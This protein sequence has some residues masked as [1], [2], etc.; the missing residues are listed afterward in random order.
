MEVQVADSGPCRKTLTIAIPPDEI[1]VR[2]DEAFATAAQ[3]VEVKGFRKGKVPRKFLEKKYGDAIRAQ[4][5][6][7]LVNQSLG[8]ACRDHDLAMVGRPDVDELGDAPLSEAEPLEFKVHLDV[9]PQFELQEVKGIEVKTGETAVSDEELET[10]LQQ[11][12]DQKKTLKSVDEPVAEGDFVKVDLEFRDET[13]T[14]VSRREDA[15][16]NTTIPVAGT[17]P[18]E[19]SSRL[20]GAERG[21]RVELELTYPEHFGVEEVRG[22]K[23]KVVIQ[24]VDVLRVTAPPVD[25]ELAKSLDFEDLQS[26]E[27]DLRTRI[28][29][30]KERSDK[31]RQ[32]EDI[33]DVV[34]NDHP[35]EL[36]RS[37]VDEQAE[38]QIKSYREQ[39]E[40]QSVEEG[41]I[42]KKLEEARDEIHNHAERRVRLFFL[43]EGI[44]RQEKIFVTETDIDVQLRNI[45][46][47]NNVPPEQVREYFSAENRLGDLRV[48]I[49]ERKVREFLREK[50]NFTD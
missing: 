36:P 31:R 25:D 37:L 43:M 48:G 2:L 42:E 39:L 33:L 41:E 35:F 30:E 24:V 16:L 50:A 5:K 3:Q 11:I 34:L 9:R 27:A 44:A 26:L 18:E 6:E 40:Q 13:G 46:A 47:E 49:M 32:E 29:A 21:S 4:A 10:A 19:F 45:A 8:T 17:D 28:Q 20:T 23:G 1:R 12:A 38:H 15:Q 22:E 14:V 7:E